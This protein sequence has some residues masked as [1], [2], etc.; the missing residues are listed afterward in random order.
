MF[1][2]YHCNLYF[3]KV[4]QISPGGSI[5]LLW[6][7]CSP[8]DSATHPAPSAADTLD[9]S[10]ESAASCSQKPASLFSSPSSRKAEWSLSAPLPRLSRSWGPCDCYLHGFCVT[11]KWKYH[12]VREPYASSRH[13]PWWWHPKRPSVQALC[14]S[15]VHYLI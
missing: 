5:R 8:S 7:R 13:Y 1:N 2:E 11:G 14:S 9:N 10:L 3:S 4:K 6:D 15:L 12:Q